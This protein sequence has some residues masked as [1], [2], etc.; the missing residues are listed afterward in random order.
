MAESTS[1]ANLSILLDE[2]GS[3]AKVRGGVEREYRLIKLS[4]E[5]RDRHGIEPA[6]YLDLYHRY[7]ASASQVVRIRT[8][9][10]LIYKGLVGAAALGA[11]L[12]A[13]NLYGF[14]S[15]QRGKSIADSWRV[16][17]EYTGQPYDGG[18]KTA[19]EILFA[20]N[21]V[22]Y[23]ADL[24][25]APLVGLDADIK[26]GFLSRF[27]S[28]F[29]TDSIE[30]QTVS[31]AKGKGCTKAELQDV[32]L[33]GAKLYMATFRFANLHR[34]NLSPFI[35]KGPKPLEIN[36]EAQVVDFSSAN[37][38]Y[39]N[40]EDANLRDSSFRNTSLANANLVGAN[41]SGADLSGADLRRTLLRKDRGGMVKLCKTKI[42]GK[43]LG[44]ED[45]LSIPSSCKEKAIILAS[46]I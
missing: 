42:D 40:L 22:L 3:I 29:R 32:D 45:L 39:A 43:T 23:N 9:G 38:S 14:L 31:S 41:L 36:T 16:I 37:L 13:L 5:A 25:R 26:C 33:R 11:A 12:S 20:Y 6:A 17:K 15:D 2:L 34:A 27:L 44:K 1:S 7:Y 21:Q 19:V 4:E 10:G 8:I 30:N 46:E 24:S 28:R 18:R 35:T